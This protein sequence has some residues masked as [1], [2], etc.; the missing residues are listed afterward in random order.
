MGKNW[1]NFTA[2]FVGQTGYV[3]LYD[4]SIGDF[5]M[6]DTYPEVYQVKNI[7]NKEIG[8][9]LGRVVETFNVTE[10]KTCDWFYDTNHSAYAPVLVKLIPNE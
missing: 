1:K 9:R 10:E 2:L 4:L 6:E 5:F 7:V 3:D 8:G